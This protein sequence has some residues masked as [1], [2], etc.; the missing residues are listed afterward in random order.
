MI[1]SPLSKPTTKKKILFLRS[2][3][4]DELARFLEKDRFEN[5]TN[6]FADIDYHDFQPA[7][8]AT[9]PTIIHLVYFY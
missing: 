7:L 1:L 2:V 5:F 9:Y 4:N 8:H 3:Q 6:L